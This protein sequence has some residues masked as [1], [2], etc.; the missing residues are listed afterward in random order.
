MSAILER[1]AHP[2]AAA[3]YLGDTLFDGCLSLVLGAGVSKPLGL[4]TWQELLAGGFAH[5]GEPPFVGGIWSWARLG[6]R[7]P[8]NGRE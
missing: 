3:T 7:L 4:P 6:W 1:L 5:I 8:A 2:R